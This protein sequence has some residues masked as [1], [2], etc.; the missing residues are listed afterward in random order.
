[1]FTHQEVAGIVTIVVLVILPTVA[2]VVWASLNPP[3]DDHE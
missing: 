2:L 3:G 1:M